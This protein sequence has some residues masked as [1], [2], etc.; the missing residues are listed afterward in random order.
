MNYNKV[1]LIGNL[2]RDPELRYLNSGTAVCDLG[3][4]VNR[5]F[6]KADGESGEET[7]F[8]DVV[9]WAR[10]AENCNQFLRKGAG[11]FVEGR[12]TFD[13][14]EN[15]EGQK[16]SKHR[17]VADRV[18]FMPRPGAP[19]SESAEV[20]EYGDNYRRDERASP[21]PARQEASEELTGPEH[22]PEVPF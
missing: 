4:A 7:C 19:T 11:V 18:Q 16:R 5:R 3:L 12:L 13:T 14:W 22:D 2:T 10:Q 6:R 1:L 20:A 8:V 15:Q 21:A 17:V 9:V